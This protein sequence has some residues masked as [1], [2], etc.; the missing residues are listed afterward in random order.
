MIFYYFKATNLPAKAKTL[1]RQ[2]GNVIKL[3][4][5]YE[6]NITPSGFWLNNCKSYSKIISSLR[7]Y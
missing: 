4:N 6:F 7:D 3:S 5:L 1:A 2:T